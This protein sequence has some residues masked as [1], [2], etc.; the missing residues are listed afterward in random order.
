MTDTTSSSDS[1][2][3]RLF[4][5]PEA[6]KDLLNHFL[7]PEEL[8]ELDLSAMHMLNTKFTAQFEGDRRRGDVVWEIP[9]RAGGSL[10][11]LLILEFQSDIDDWMV[12]RLDVYT[13]LLYQQLV[14]ERK[15]KVTDGLPPV[16]PIVL[17]N[18]DHRWHAATSLQELIRLPEG[19]ALW[20]YQPQMRY[21]LISQINFSNE[22]LQKYDSFVALFF[23]MEHP[24]NPKEMMHTIHDLVS[25][26]QNH[27]DAPPVKHLFRELLI[28]GLSRFKVP[29]PHTHIP[30]DLQEMVNMLTTRFEQ[31]AHDYEMKGYLAGEMKGQ[32]EGRQEGRQEGQAKILVRQLMRRFG[33]LP[34]AI[35][36]KITMANSNTLEMWA[37]LVLP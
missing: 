14:N 5:H 27:P 22:E 8:T 33:E 15:L 17:H 30:E 4:A 19:S 26:F 10:F 31:W 24:A 7:S 25:W 6:V 34:A 1:I 12:L 13:G 3:H 20:K 37:D 23:R 21:Y 35:H 32:Q 11:V 29:N 18:G 28:A 16:L 36:E 9:L 2:Y